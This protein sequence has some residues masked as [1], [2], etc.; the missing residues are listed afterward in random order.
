MRRRPTAIVRRQGFEDLYRNEGDRLWRAVF[1]FA[2]DRGVADDA[3]SEAFAQCIRRGTEVRDPRAWVWRA[4]FR[5]AAGELKERGRWESLPDTDRAEEPSSASA[6]LDALVQL[7]ARQR[8]VLLLFHY[9]G[10]A[11]TEIAQMLG[12]AAPTVR[13]HLTRGRRR[14]RRLLEEEN[15]EP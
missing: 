3:V 12:M 1:A 2:G 7:P 13:V 4:A 8:A 5:I 11:S 14:L 6:L 10:Y 9:A 15:D